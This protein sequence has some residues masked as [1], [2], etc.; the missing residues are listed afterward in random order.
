MPV[1][2]HR[3]RREEHPHHRIIIARVRVVQPRAVVVLPDEAFGRVDAAHIVTPRPVWS[4]Q[5]ITLEGGP[6]RRVG[7]GRDNAA[8]RIAQVELRA[9]AVQRAERRPARKEKVVRLDQMKGKLL[10]L[11]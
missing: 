6:S 1:A 8:Q 7:E 4:E 10:T 5:L 3:V 9:V 11:P 2:L